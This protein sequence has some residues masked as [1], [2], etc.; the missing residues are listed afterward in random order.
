VA[1]AGRTLSLEHRAAVARGT[2][3]HG[4]SGKGRNDDSPTYVSW[5]NMR[6]RCAPGG[7]YHG[8]VTVCERWR[9][10]EA[11]LED[12]GPRPDGRTLDRIDNDRGYEPGNCRW[13]T[14]VEQ[15][16]NRRQRQKERV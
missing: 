12:M 5:R 6:D 1:L 16:N 14:P 13:A 10:F 11:F 8:R 15:A 9:S 7:K 4:Q 2:T 3:T